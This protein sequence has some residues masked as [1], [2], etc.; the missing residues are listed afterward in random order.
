MPRIPRLKFSA[1]RA[2][3]RWAL[4]VAFVIALA[5][6]FAAPHAPLKPAADRIEPRAAEPAV[7]AAARARQAYGELPL[8]FEAN[9]GQTDAS[10]KFLARGSGYNLFLTSDEAVLDLH[11][12]V[13][14]EADERAV[15]R[16]RLVGS[17]PSPTVEGQQPLEARSNYFSG[18]DSSG[19]PVSAETY[20]RVSYAGVYDG[21]DAVY[22]GNQGRLE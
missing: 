7:E 13:A 14:A 12:R 17:N 6:Y 18:G 10:V 5:G 16:M 3:S 15:L 2:L 9:R 4:A 8:Q 21:V 11:R 22:Y 19:S 1:R 20:A